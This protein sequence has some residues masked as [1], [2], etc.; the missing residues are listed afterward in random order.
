MLGHAIVILSGTC[1]S[2]LI[3]LVHFL[4]LIIGRCAEHAEPLKPKYMIQLN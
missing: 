2:E 4:D 1:D 3:A